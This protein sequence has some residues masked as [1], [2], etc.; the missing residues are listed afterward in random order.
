M[1]YGIAL[2]TSLIV[3][4]GQSTFAQ[5]A[6]DP[7]PPPPPELEEEAPAPAAPAKK[8]PKVD[9]CG[10]QTA[11]TCDG[12]EYVG[13]LGGDSWKIGAMGAALCSRSADIEAS[14]KRRKDRIEYEELLQDIAEENEEQYKPWVPSETNREFAQRTTQE[15]ISN[16]DFW[17]DEMQFVAADIEDV[18]I[19]IQALAVVEAACTP[20]K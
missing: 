12:I 9:H 20:P 19:Q 5:E 1:K 4:W 7:P 16:K 3:I 15:C 18:D 11:K 2:V 13:E 14:R 6:S 17:C 8:K 10:P